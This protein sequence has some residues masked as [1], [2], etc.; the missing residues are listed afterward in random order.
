MQTHINQN[1]C[2]LRSIRTDADSDQ[3]E[4][5][6]TQI[7]QNRCR[8]GLVWFS[9][10]PVLATGLNTIADGSV[11]FWAL[12]TSSSS[13]HQASRA[14]V[15]RP[16]KAVATTGKGSSHGGGRRRLPPTRLCQHPNQ[17]KPTP[18]TQHSPKTSLVTETR[19]ATVEQG[20]ANQTKEVVK[21]RPMVGV[22]S[23][24]HVVEAVV[25]ASPD[26]GCGKRGFSGEGDANG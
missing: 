11:R 12:L 14:R 17:T 23:T 24:T 2:R 21:R 22:V 3:S 4:Q 16:P 8:L 10:S 13:P 18:T 7:N 9:S 20:S 1:R 19:R 5:M 26:G 25:G 6:Q 15:P